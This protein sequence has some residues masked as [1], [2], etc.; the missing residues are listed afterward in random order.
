MQKLSLQALAREHLSRATASSAGRSAET[1]YG[2]HER[3]LRQTLIAL[4]AGT[5]LTEHEDPGEATLQVLSGRV[6]LTA[7]EDGWDGRTGDFLVIPPARHDLRA[8]EDAVV[9]LTVGGR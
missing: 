1:I 9:L 4:R 3:S 7:G 6:R 8:V 2:G 5:T